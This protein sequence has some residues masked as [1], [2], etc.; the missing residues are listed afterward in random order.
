MLRECISSLRPA[1]APVLHVAIGLPFANLVLGNQFVEETKH[2]APEFKNRNLKGKSS[3]SPSDDVRV[4]AS[5]EQ[6]A[7]RCSGPRAASNSELG[8]ESKA[9][10]HMR[11][12]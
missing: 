11:K 12:K 6:A 4:I 3:I 7:G 10:R 8:R 2:M 9:L 1:T 5:H